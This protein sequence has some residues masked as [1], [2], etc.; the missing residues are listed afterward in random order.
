MIVLTGYCQVQDDKIEE[1]LE[2]CHE[3]RAKA[4]VE[5]GCERFDYYMSIEEHMKCVF[6]EEWSSMAHL[7]AHFATAHFADFMTK[8]KEC[9]AREPEVRIFEATLRA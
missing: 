2:A 1:F 5:A 8:A 7:E 3:N 9:L 4:L 6:V